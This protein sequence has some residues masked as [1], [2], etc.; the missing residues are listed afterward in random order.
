V[1]TPGR[2]PQPAEQEPDQGQTAGVDLDRVPANRRHLM[3]RITALRK[4]DFNTTDGIGEYNRFKV[5][6][7]RDL[8]KIRQLERLPEQARFEMQV[9][10]SVLPFRVKKNLVKKIITCTVDVQLKLAGM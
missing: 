5:Y 10:S 4:N 1:H 9:V 3:N 8:G 6:T 7:Q 2:G